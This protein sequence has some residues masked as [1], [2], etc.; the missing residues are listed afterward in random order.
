MKKSDD[1]LETYL[2]YELAPY[3]LSVF[4]DVGLRKS[5]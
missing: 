5:T 4:D 1:E 2:K 3:P